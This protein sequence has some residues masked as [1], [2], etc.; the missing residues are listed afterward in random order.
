MAQT[1]A[2]LQTALR[3]EAN[4]VKN[5]GGI[6]IRF[7][8]IFTNGSSKN[9]KLNPDGTWKKKPTATDQGMVRFEWIDT[10]HSPKADDGV[11]VT[12]VDKAYTETI[13]P[14]EVIGW[15]FNYD[16]ETTSTRDIPSDQNE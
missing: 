8:L 10:A 7:T 9:Y 6:N 13:D 15:E 11:T 14:A 2:D 4:T 16:L 12:Y 3:T 5:M 1:A